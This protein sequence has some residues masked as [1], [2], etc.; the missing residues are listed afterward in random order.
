MRK[1]PPKKPLPASLFERMSEAQRD[2]PPRRQGIVA[3]FTCHCGCQD[4]VLEPA[5]A[6]VPC[7]GCGMAMRRWSPKH[8]PP[9]S[10]ARAWDGKARRI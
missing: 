9:T 10:N 4:E 7:W 2:P 5:P 8:E 1:K 6:E 3:S